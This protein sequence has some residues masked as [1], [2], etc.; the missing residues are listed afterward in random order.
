MDEKSPRVTLLELVQAVQD[1]CRS[2]AE[3]VA[4]IMHMVNTRRVVLRGIFARHRFA[5]A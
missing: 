3:V 2:D 4:V 1:N 5:T